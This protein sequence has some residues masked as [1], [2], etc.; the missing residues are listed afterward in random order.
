M[1]CAT[2]DDRQLSRD[3]ANLQVI[4]HGSPA[5]TLPCWQLAALGAQAVNLKRRGRIHK[6]G[7]DCRQLRGKLGN[8]REVVFSTEFILATTEEG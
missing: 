4:V 6:P 7:S 8:E 2:G 1:A 3:E 5:G